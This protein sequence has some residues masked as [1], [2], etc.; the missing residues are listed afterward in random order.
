MSTNSLMTVGVQAM[1]AAQTQLSTTSHNIVNAA[2]E[3]YSRQ[4]V[5]LTTVP[6]RSSGAGYIGGGVAVDTVE[7]AANRFL[8]AQN[9]QTQAQSA[10]DST[11]VDMLN[12][13][14]GGYVLGEQ[15]LGQAASK[16]FASFGEMAAAP[17]DESVRQVA[18]SAAESLA[19][20]FRS[21]GEHIDSL[22]TSVTQ[23]LGDEVSVVNGLTAQIA[24][25][26]GQLTG[27]G[28]AKDQPND[29][30]DQRDQLIAQLSQH[31]EVS[32]IDNRGQDDKLDGSISLFVGGGQ[33][34]VMGRHQP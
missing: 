29:L 16:L 10:A 30:L 24:K 1:F 26:N 2:V 13:L 27:S 4:S 11:R 31:I 20:R 8:T 32:R 28:S 12:Q 23:Q 15:G 5:R 19:S 14:E 25:I 33:P 18:L 7:R 34:L 9:N 6:G 21:T 3:G 17:T 22:Q